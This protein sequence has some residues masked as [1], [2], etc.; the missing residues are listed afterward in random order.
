M[1]ERRHL[2]RDGRR[3]TRRQMGWVLLLVTLSCAPQ[4]ASAEPSA[5]HVT[6]HDRLDDAPFDADALFNVGLAEARAG[7][8]SHA[9][10]ALE[11]A[12]IAAPMDRE[13]EDVLLA[14]RA[15]ARRRRAS[16]Q[17]SG[18]FVEGEPPGI[19]WWRFFRAIPASWTMGALWALVWLGSMALVYRR[20]TRP[21]TTPY[22]VATVFA[23]ASLVGA[24]V[25]GSYAVGRTSTETIVVP[26]VVTSDAPRVRLAP[27][28]LASEHPD[29]DLYPGAVV[30]VLEERG[31]WQELELADG[32]R[33]WVLPGVVERIIP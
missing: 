16:E 3:R 6:L 17:A 8:V 15:E 5:D 21:G 32:D 29:R 18:T 23:V 24:S 22:D 31:V 20:T 13:I 11:R 14:A 33:V 30:R 9:I 26:A 25:A 4:T 10:L 12:R 7:R 2:L 27:D 19:A 1:T 28:E